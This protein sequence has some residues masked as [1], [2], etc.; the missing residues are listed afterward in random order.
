[1]RK[2]THTHTLP[3]RESAHSAAI[4]HCITLLC[5]FT[6]ALAFALSISL[7]CS[8][9]MASNGRSW[10]KKRGSAASCPTEVIPTQALAFTALPWT[11]PWPHPLHNNYFILLIYT[12]YLHLSFY[13]YPLDSSKDMHFIRLYPAKHR[14]V[15]CLRDVLWVQASIFCSHRE[16]MPRPRRHSRGLL[17]KEQSIFWNSTCRPYKIQ[18]RRSWL[19]TVI[20]TGIPFLTT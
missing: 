17:N 9:S 5:T 11:W 3:R 7:P 14:G 10:Q 12:K 15:W 20:L 16:I 1:M 13:N 8:V 2:Y 18:T 4:S 6:L 19:Y